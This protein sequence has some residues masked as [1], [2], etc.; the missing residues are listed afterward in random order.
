MNIDQAIHKL[1]ELIST[2]GQLRLHDANEADTRRK[3]ID[4][5]ITEVLGWLPADINYEEHVDDSDGVKY[6]DYIIRTLTTGIII[7]AKRAG[8]DFELPNNRKTGQLS[9]FLS[10]GSVGSAIKQASAYTIQKRL[11]FSVVTNGSAWIVFCA[12]RTDGI[13]VNQSYAV[14]FRSLEDIRERFVEFW[15]LLSRQRVT[16]GCLENHFLRG[17]DIKLS[18]R[19]I[20]VINNAG[21]KVG[22]SQFYHA[23]ESAVAKALTDEAILDDTTA[24]EKCYVSDA[25]RTKYDSR[26]RLHLPNRKPE[27][28]RKTL[29]PQL[30]TG[31]LRK[32]NSEIS[33]AKPALP[34]FLLLLGSVGA[35]KTTFLHH[36]WKVSATK[37][38]TKPVI[39]IYIDFKAATPSIDPRRFIYNSLLSF[40]EKDTTHSLG[41]WDQTIKHAY[42]DKI[43]ALKRGPMSLLFKTD[44]KAFSQRISEIVMKDHDEVEP[45]VEKLL[46]HTAKK[47]PIYLAIDNVDQL[48][49]EELCS[50]IFLEAQSCARQLR[51]NIIISLRDSTYFRHR[52]TPIF[53]AFE[54]DT[55][56]IDP[57]SVLPVISRRFAYAKQLLN[58]QKANITTQ[59]GEHFSIGNV[60]DLF[61]VIGKSVLEDPCGT[62]V[63]TLAGGNIRRALSLTR[64]FLASNHAS[65]DRVLYDFAAGRPSYFPSHE[66]F[67]GAVYGQ[68]AHYREEESLLLN[69]F[70]SKIGS[71]EVQ[72]LRVSIVRQLVAQAESGAGM[73]LIYGSTAEDLIHLGINI[74]LTHKVISDLI[75]GGFIATKDGQPLAE[76]STLVA[77]RLGGYAIRHLCF[78]FAYLEACSID[79]SVYDAPAWGE[80]CNTSREIDESNGMER[81]RLRFRR[82]NTFLDYLHGAELIWLTALNRHRITSLSA[83]AFIHVIVKPEFTNRFENQ[84]VPSAQ[85]AFRERK[86]RIQSLRATS[87]E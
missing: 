81:L 46:A 71:R 76:R 9:G 64:E 78:E 14:I 15:N 60:A 52:N 49:S 16:E 8:I 63:E 35:G 22:R 43:D 65:T 36:F 53:D 33:E 26:L 17:S 83:D 70:D 25:E 1:T 51:C 18:N 67:K 41:D 2:Y 58:G 42:H 57:P 69:I 3:V 6:A 7:E 19:L 29:R 59:R 80:L 21:F 39:W 44:E 45:Y 12:N 13:D 50:K 73:G 31:D 10:A 75:T 4:A 68:R 28:D 30:S 86:E 85:K 48:D 47:I 61:D 34:Q 72:L 5:I 38:N 77:T 62:M 82:I 87:N 55:V 54:V 56:Y 11:G 84:V 79:S 66:F 20:G 23:I 32:L 40:I 37:N 27:L 74:E 24:L